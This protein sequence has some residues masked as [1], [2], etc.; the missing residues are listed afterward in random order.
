MRLEIDLAGDVQEV[1]QAVPVPII[2]L[3]NEGMIVV[4][5]MEAET[6]LGKGSPLIGS[7]AEEVLPPALLPGNGPEHTEC[8]WIDG[9]GN[10][11]NVRFRR[12]GSTGAVQGTLIALGTQSA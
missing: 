4:A 3:D 5:N 11:W 7:F 12:L 10:R 6:L 8:V 1:L 2:G 9:R